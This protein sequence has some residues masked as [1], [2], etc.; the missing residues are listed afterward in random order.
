MEVHGKIRFL[1]RVHKKPVYSGDCLKRR[2]AWTVCR[3]KGALGKKEEFVFEGGVDI[4]MHTMAITIIYNDF[5][6]N[7]LK[8]TG[9]T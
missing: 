2:G 5:H 3:F 6:S 9:L 8:F 1:R 4:P 7:G